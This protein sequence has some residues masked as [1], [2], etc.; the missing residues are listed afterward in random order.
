MVAAILSSSTLW[1]RRG[2]TR[3]PM[4]LIRM[5]KPNCSLED[6]GVTGPDSSIQQQGPSL[7]ALA[8]LERLL[9]IAHPVTQ[10]KS[11]TFIIPEGENQCFICT[12]RQKTLR[13][14]YPDKQKIS[15]ASVRV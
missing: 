12:Y 10:R 6:P 13:M 15:I 11:F 2:R 9:V 4:S 14:P 7:S 3:S 8:S 1:E 5:R